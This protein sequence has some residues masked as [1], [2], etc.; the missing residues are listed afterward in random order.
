MRV[1][2]TRNPKAEGRKKPEIRNP[3]R[4]SREE[5]KRRKKENQK[6]KLRGPVFF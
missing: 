6:K 2:K 4:N 5:R 1:A 3:K